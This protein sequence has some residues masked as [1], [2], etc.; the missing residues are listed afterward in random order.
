[1]TATV[2]Q[3]G[4][5]AMSDEKSAIRRLLEAAKREYA[6][7]GAWPAFKSGEWL[8]LLIQRSFKNYW[9]RATVEYFSQKYGTTDPEKI[10]PKLIAV[11][12]KNAAILGA[13]T[14]GPG[15]W[16]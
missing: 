9:E 6:E 3:I 5:P 8:W 10:A 2:I 4:R 15:R 12:A 11:A 13:L 7:L 14:V 1:V 16:F